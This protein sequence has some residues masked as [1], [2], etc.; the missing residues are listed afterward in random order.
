MGKPAVTLSNMALS[1]ARHPSPNVVGC[2]L[3]QGLPS[4]PLFDGGVML[5]MTEV[6]KLVAPE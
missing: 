1:L 2:G 6:L 4:A 3:A 5:T